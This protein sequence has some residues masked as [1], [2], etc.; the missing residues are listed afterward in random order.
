MMTPDPALSSS[1]PRDIN[2]RGLVVGSSFKNL[3]VSDTRTV[4]GGP[5]GQDVNT[6]ISRQDPHQPFV[7]LKVAAHIN[8][9]GQIV[10]QGVDSRQPEGHISWYLL[11]P[12]AAQ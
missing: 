12:V 8:N 9:R 1:Q 10:A 7:S 5:R 6:L 4:W 2:N 11:T 3:Q